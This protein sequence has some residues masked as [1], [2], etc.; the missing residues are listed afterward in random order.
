MPEGLCRY[1]WT[2]EHCGGNGVA[3]LLDG[4]S[5][6]GFVCELER[7]HSL[8]CGGCDGNARK[9]LR[10]RRRNLSDKDWDKVKEAAK[11]KAATADHSESWMDKWLWRV[12]P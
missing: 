12:W 2:C 5:D 8:A 9:T 11:R 3:L 6:W 4:L 1:E 10:V 7:A